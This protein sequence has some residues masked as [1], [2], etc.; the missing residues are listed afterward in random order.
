M[1]Q[2]DVEEFRHKYFQLYGKQINTTDSAFPIIF[3]ILTASWKLDSKTDGLDKALKVI[4]Q[5]GDVIQS[6][7]DQA[8]TKLL[9]NDE[10]TAAA[11]WRGKR[12]YFSLITAVSCILLSVVIFALYQYTESGKLDKFY[13]NSKKE[14]IEG[15]TYIML[16]PSKKTFII[17][18]NYITLED[19][20]IAI[21]VH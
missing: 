17:G 6:R 8:K 1:K 19:G 16:K 11:W 15:T 10:Q 13:E 21:P 18:E 3:S 9:I 12:H 20:S 14:T 5:A 2:N 4:E 7:S